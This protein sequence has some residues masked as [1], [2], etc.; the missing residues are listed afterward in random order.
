M[1]SRTGSL[2]KVRA[3]LDVHLKSEERGMFMTNEERETVEMIADVPIRA[4]E[5]LMSGEAVNNNGLRSIKGSY[6]P[7]Q[8]T[9]REKPTES[10]AQTIFVNVAV[11]G[12]DLLLSEVIIPLTNRF[13]M[14][15]VYPCL[16]ER[17]EKAKQRRPKKPK[18]KGNVRETGLECSS[19]IIKIEDYQ[20][21]A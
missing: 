13:V 7:E 5:A 1:C 21:G 11:Y 16:I 10:M 6:Y 19:N 15:K 9:L 8:P 14:E 2:Y 17:R 18:S 20:K 3:Q 4:Y 12:L